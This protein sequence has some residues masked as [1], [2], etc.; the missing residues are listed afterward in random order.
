MK[1]VALF[2]AA[3][4][5]VSSVPA[6]A[7]LYSDFNSYGLFGRQVTTSRPLEDSFSVNFASPAEQA[8]WGEATFLIADADKYQEQFSVQLG[9]V[10]GFDSGKIDDFSIFGISFELAGGVVGTLLADINADGILNYRITA[11]SGNFN[12]LWANL[13]VRTEDI[14]TSGD[15]VTRV[16]DGGLTLALLGASMVGLYA[17]RRRA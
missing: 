7:A 16:P 5:V 3:V 14:G 11:T 13:N 17:F 9:D 10:S 8:V 2:A 4:L 15:P 12:V 6:T 1:T